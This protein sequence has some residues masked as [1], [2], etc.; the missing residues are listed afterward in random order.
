[1][2]GVKFISRVVF[3]TNM[4]TSTGSLSERFR[5]NQVYLHLSDY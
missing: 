3:L 1:M 5:A 4:S 2:S